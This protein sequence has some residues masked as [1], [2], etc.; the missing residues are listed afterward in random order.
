VVR[1]PTLLDCSTGRLWRSDAD[2]QMIVVVDK[3]RHGLRRPTER[4]VRADIDRH[5]AGGDEQVDELLCALDVDL[6][7]RLRGPQAR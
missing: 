2:V 7:D 3:R 4:Q 1:A 5:R 6:I